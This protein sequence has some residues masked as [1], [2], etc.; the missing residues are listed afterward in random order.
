[1]TQIYYVVVLIIRSHHGEFELLMAR[2]AEEKYMGGTWQLISGGLEPNETAWQGALREMREETELTP[3]EFYRLSTLTNFYRPDNDSLNTAPMF[4]AIVEENA[5]VT[6]NHEHSEF[7]WVD[8]YEA[9]S[10]LMW[11][12]DREAL[13]ELRSVILDNA[14]AKEFMRIPLPLNL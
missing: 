8:V 11:P 4:C 13:D 5:S 12:S 3:I 6:I 9:D 1:M 10:K 14:L 7:E 2:R